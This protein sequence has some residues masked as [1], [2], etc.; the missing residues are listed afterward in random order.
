[1]T[2][3][4][5]LSQGYRLEQRIK[6]L[7]E[8][9]EELRLLSTT[10]SSP[11]FEE[12]YSASRNTDAPFEKVLYKIMELEKRYGTMLY[13][14]LTFKA[15]L[16][17]VIEAVENKDHRMVLHYRYIDNHTWVEIGDLLGWDAKTIRRWH[18]KALSS[19]VVP[20]HPMIID[21]FLEN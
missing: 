20:E 12:H 15:E 9:I 3:K 17:Q 1:M 7:Q 10:V 13:E 11:G 8:E 16:L 2:A 14:L 18:N 5:Y 21:K 6:M 4:E 19:V